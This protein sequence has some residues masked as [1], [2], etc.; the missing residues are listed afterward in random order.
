MVLPLATG[1]SLTLVFLALKQESLKQAQAKALEEASESGPAVDSE[2]AAP[3]VVSERKEKK[4]VIWSRIDQKSC[5]KSIVTAGL[6]P[7][8]VELKRD[9]D[10]LCTDVE[11][12]ERAIMEKGPDQIL[13]LFCTTSTFAPRVPDDVE[14]VS[15]LAKKYGLPFVVNNAYGLQCSKIMHSLEMA[16]RKGR[17]DAVV[18][19][20]DKNFMVPVGGAI[21]AAGSADRVGLLDKVS[22]CYPGRASGS[23]VLDLFITFLSMGSSGL[24]SLW[25]ERKTLFEWFVGELKAVVAKHGLDVLGTQR[26]NKI[27]VC[28]DLSALL[29]SASE[30][31][32]ARISDVKELNALGAQLFNHRVSGP[33]VVACPAGS[34]KI[35]AYSFSNYGAHSDGYEKPY[36]ATAAAM[37]ATREELE[38]FLTRLDE[39]LTQFGGS[40]E[41]DDAGGKKKGKKK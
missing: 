21:L 11:A 17:L 40:G 39:A 5:F 4:F 13:A 24:S 9:G 10:S 28:V 20:T 15:L 8:V 18:Q 2:K 22:Q 35:D 16:A 37:G 31:G 34:K 12:F 6:E 7:V 32:T 23:A 36:L 3:A 33:R 25:K 27:S 41:A 1:M 38:L 30:G 19:S 29:S 26:G 14:A